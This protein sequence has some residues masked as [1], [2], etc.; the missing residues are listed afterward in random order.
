[1]V[2]IIRQRGGSPSPYSYN[3]YPSPT[4][5][6]IPD[7]NILLAKSIKQCLCQLFLSQSRRR[8][9]IFAGRAKSK[10]TAAYPGFFGEMAQLSGDCVTSHYRQVAAA[11]IKSGNAGMLLLPS[12]LSFR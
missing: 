3:S 10:N 12:S 4:W 5:L 9:G 11:K 6:V 8:S 2:Q 1:M 7:A